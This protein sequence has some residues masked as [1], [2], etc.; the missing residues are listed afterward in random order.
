MGKP[1]SLGKEGGFLHALFPQETY[2]KF[3]FIL[4]YTSVSLRSPRAL[5]VCA[6][7]RPTLPGAIS[8]LR[9]IAFAACRRLGQK[10]GLITF[11]LRTAIARLTPCASSTRKPL[12]CAPLSLGSR[13]ALRPHA[14]AIVFLVYKRVFGVPQGHLVG[15]QPRGAECAS[16]RETRLY[17]Q[18][19][20]AF[21]A[22]SGKRLRQFPA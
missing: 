20:D 15:T 2:N 17:P 8:A 12:P 1:P 11:A 14:N 4:L 3:Y 13:R 5:F 22:N 19:Y 18:K 10:G 21:A 16:L 9:L 6:R 7:Q